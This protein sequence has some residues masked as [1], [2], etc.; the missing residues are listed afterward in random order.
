MNEKIC[1]L[2]MLRNVINLSKEDFL[3]VKIPHYLLFRQNKLVVQNEILPRKRINK[4][5]GSLFDQCLT[6]V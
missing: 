4:R 2:L 3:E 5:F 6:N 1:I